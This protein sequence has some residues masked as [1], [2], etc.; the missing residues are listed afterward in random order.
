MRAPS[1]EPRCDGCRRCKAGVGPGRFCNGSSTMAIGRT[2]SPTGHHEVKTAGGSTTEESLGMEEC[3][4]ELSYRSILTRE[5]K[6]ELHDDRS[7]EGRRTPPCKNSPQRGQAR[8]ERAAGTHPSLRCLHRVGL[9]LHRP[10][11]LGRLDLRLIE[12]SPRYFPSGIER[13]SLRECPKINRLI[14]VDFLHA[15]DHDVPHEASRT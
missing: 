1:V 10:L 3:A 9:V 15:L 12:I 13:H 5:G 14:G 11:P 8:R 2:T 7:E 6:I 4:W